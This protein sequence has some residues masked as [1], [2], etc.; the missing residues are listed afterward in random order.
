MKTFQIMKFYFAEFGN[1]PREFANQANLN[2]QFGHF[3][4]FGNLIN[5]N[6]S[7]KLAKFWQFQIF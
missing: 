6:V 3:G 4:N 7:Q 1:L 2:F 5:E